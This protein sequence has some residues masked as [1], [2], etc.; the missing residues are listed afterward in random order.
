[1]AK[2]RIGDLLVSSCFKGRISGKAI[3]DC[4]IGEH[5]NLHPFNVAPAY[6]RY[7]LPFDFDDYEKKGP[8][9]FAITGV[10]KR[11]EAATFARPS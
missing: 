1:M 10:Q 7:E 6:L 4:Q 11:S 3:G 8:I 5:K 2:S 9:T